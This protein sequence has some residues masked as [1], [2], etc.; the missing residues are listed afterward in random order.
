[1]T[2]VGAFY[3][4]SGKYIEHGPYLRRVG[5]I[6]GCRQHSADFSHRRRHRGKMVTNHQPV[7][8]AAMEGLF[9]T[10]PARRWS[11]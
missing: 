8:L 3:L 7:T 4:L 5:V 10:Q 1:M 6:A 2:A 11:S 9:Q